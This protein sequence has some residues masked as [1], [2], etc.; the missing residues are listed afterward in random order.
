MA[1]ISNG[2][3]SDV[4]E[5]DAISSSP[6]TNLAT[7][8]PPQQTADDS[9]ERDTTD[10]NIPQ[11]GRKQSV[12]SNSGRKL[13]ELEAIQIAAAGDLNIINAEIDELDVDL[14][15]LPRSNHW[16]NYE[17]KFKDPRHF[18]YETCFSYK[19]HLYHTY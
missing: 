12:Y 6:D 1:D 11:P 13:T 10:D 3:S 19:P 15:N 8:T 7:N 16:F 14:Q 2:V 17:L 4:A 9:E 5:K 18:T